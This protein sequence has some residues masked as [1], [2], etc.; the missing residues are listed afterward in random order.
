[1]KSKRFGYIRVSTKDQNVDR[2]LDSM[3]KLEIDDRDLFI[4]K[5][6]GRN[7]QRDQ[8]QLMKR[9]LRQGD[10]LY[11]HTLDRF[12]RNKTEILQEWTDITK[13]IRADIVVLDMP[14][15]DTTKYKDSLG[16]FIADLVLQIL[17]WTAENERTKIRQ[18]QREG[19]DAALRKGV[20]FGRPEV[21]ITDDF[22]VVY[23]KWKN[24]EI[25]AVEAMR[26]SDTKK[27]TFYRLVHKMNENQGL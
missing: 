21:R 8:Y 3:H 14:L 9:M 4:D 22:K 6:S 25:T 12:G 11:I 18:N 20:R 24:K 1:M 15:L 13:H 19:I 2:Q 17:S 26:E 27:T 16:S 7:F 10:I 23:E 5:Q